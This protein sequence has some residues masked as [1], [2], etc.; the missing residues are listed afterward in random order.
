MHEVGRD[1]AIA[2][3]ESLLGKSMLRLLS[4]DAYRL[5]QQTGPRSAVMHFEQE[6]CWIESYLLGAGEGTFESVGVKARFEV[7]RDDPYNGR[8]IIHW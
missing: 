5:L 4:N 1:N 8:H 6:Y 3:S 7:E 2:F